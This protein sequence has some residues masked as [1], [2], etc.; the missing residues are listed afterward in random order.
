[1]KLLAFLLVA[2]SAAGVATAGP[3]TP[4]NPPA[5]TA[6]A[7][8]S[9]AF[10][11][12]ASSLEIQATGS[13]KLSAA[14]EPLFEIEEGGILLVRERRAKHVRVLTARKGAVIWTVDGKERAFDDE[15]KRW[16][17][18]IL[19]ARPATPIPPSAPKK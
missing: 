10:K 3:P 16:L 4:P 2:A 7:T 12:G 1:M 19:R 5:P 17:R 14:S 18:A 13:V 8:S 11:N 9:W 15:G 6:P